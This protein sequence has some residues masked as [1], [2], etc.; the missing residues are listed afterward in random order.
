MIRP[1]SMLT[2][3]GIL[4]LC[5]LVGVGGCDAPASRQ[6]HTDRATMA[7]C[8]D[9]ANQVYDRNH[10]AE[11]YSINQAG[12]PYSGSYIADNQTNYLATQY[13]N[14]RLIDDCVRNTEPGTGP[15]TPAA[16][17]PDKP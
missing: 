7:A 10:R 5:L 3:T 14:Q 4:T 6:S 8:R 9:Y 17:P 12:L 13:G 16:A 11:I 2:P 15:D 1:K